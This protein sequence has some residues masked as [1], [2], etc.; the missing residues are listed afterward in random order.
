MNMAI[1]TLARVVSKTR[2]GHAPS[3]FA[4]RD[5]YYIILHDP[6]AL[7]QMK[8]EL[9]D[10]LKPTADTIEQIAKD[11]QLLAGEVMFDTWN[12]GNRSSY[13]MI[14]AATPHM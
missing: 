5:D 9:L 14:Q 12:P 11:P 3:C 8:T 6:Y 1:A 7:S 4:A 13:S 10:A 2:T